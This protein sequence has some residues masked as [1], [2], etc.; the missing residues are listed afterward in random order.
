MNQDNETREENKMGVMPC[1]RLLITM[2][3]PM[4][5]SMLVQALYNVID[6]IFVARLSEEALTAV[7]MAFPI[8]NLMIGVAGGVAVGMNALLSKAL[9]EKRFKEANNMAMHGIFLCAISYVIFL[10]LG[11]TIIRPFY[12]LQG[13]SA[14]IAEYGTQYLSIVTC[15]SFGIFTE[16]IFE[17]LLQSTGR[18]IYTMFTQGLGAIINIF[19]DPM[20]IFG[21]GI[22]PELGIRGAAVAT[23]TGQIIAAILAIFFNMRYN[24]VDVQLSFKDFRPRG[25]AI[26]NILYIGIP[27]MIM[28]AI[29]SLMTFLVNRIVVVFGSTAVAVVGVFS[30]LQSF[31]FMPVFGLNNGMVPIVSYNYGAKKPKRIM[32]T[33]ELAMFYATCV[34]AIALIIAQSLPRQLLLLFSASEDML[35]MGIPAL[36]TVSISYLFAGICIV[37]GSVFQALGNGIYSMIVSFMRQIVFLVPLVWLFTRTGNINLVWWAWPIAELVSIGCSLFFFFRIYS[38]KVKP[39]YDETD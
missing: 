23:V 38:N 25:R 34:M 35:G 10:I 24:R 11:L 12:I 15:V 17:R 33:A 5:L 22:F 19:L 21:I 14:E 9:G 31:A 29:G 3:V 13:A 26:G 18:T 4:M 2:S 8:Q 20:L 7:S 32:R 1:N 27:S 30:K 37:M 39:L 6:S 36:R 28:V 16:M